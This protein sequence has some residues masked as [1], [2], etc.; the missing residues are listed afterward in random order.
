MRENDNGYI[1]ATAQ[2]NSEKSEIIKVA[3]T[4]VFRW[5]SVIMAIFVVFI[6]VWTSFF[7]IVK[8]SGESMLPTIK[9][10]T[11]VAVSL[12]DY[13]P[14]AGDVVVIS[15][16]NERDTIIKRIIATENQTVSVDYNEGKVY[17]DGKELCEPYV[18]NPMTEI[19]EDELVYPYVVPKGCVFVMGDNRDYSYDSRSFDIK[20]IDEDYILGKVVYK[21]TQDA[22]KTIK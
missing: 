22:D 9:S 16:S 11:F 2:E 6:V 21:L 18:V 12:F 13:E 19:R 10:G 14:V 20:A 4:S 1:Y 8:V 5:L 3:L 7:Q 15:P 17:V